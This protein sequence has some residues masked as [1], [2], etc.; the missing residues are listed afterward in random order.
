[1]QFSKLTVD[2]DAKRA[3]M[4]GPIQDDNTLRIFSWVGREEVLWCFSKRVGHAALRYALNGNNYYISLYPAA[5]N[6]NVLR[7]PATFSDPGGDREN[8]FRPE[9][10]NKYHFKAYQIEDIPPAKMVSM[11]D[12]LKRILSVNEHG[13]AAAAPAV[14][15]TD[16][17]P[18]LDDDD[19]ALQRLF[20]MWS[21]SGCEPFCGSPAGC[22][23]YYLCC[24]PPRHNCTSIIVLLLK[25]AGIT[26]DLS[27]A[28]VWLNQ[29]FF[30]SL[31]ITTGYG[32]RE[33]EEFFS[34]DTGNTKLDEILGITSVVLGLGV[35]LPIVYNAFTAAMET[36]IKP[37]NKLIVALKFPR[38]KLLSCLRHSLCL[39]DHTMLKI[40]SWVNFAAALLSLI[41]FTAILGV[42]GFKEEGNLG[43]SGDA[44][45]TFIIPSATYFT[46]MAALAFG[47]IVFS[48]CCHRETGCITPYAL[49][50]VFDRIQDTMP[51][52]DPEPEPN[53]EDGAQ[54]EEAS[55]GGGVPAERR[56]RVLDRIQ[57]TMPQPQ[58]D[59]DSSDSS[60]SPGE[61][62]ETTT[63]AVVWTRNALHAAAI[64][65]AKGQSSTDIEL[66]I[67]T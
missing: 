43:F 22:F 23:T 13:Q 47:Q 25:K 27:C 53:V 17:I 5:G 3:A 52:P 49:S 58:P 48:A 1:M 29:F 61:V 60:D 8:Y 12:A 65:E 66:V 14:D 10:I 37:K 32:F 42:R 7:T 35:G 16:Q 20:K 59:P 62:V 56:L 6:H 57:D 34:G 63:A 2:T 45:E 19:A 15:F 41:I 67:R 51:Q 50:R 9:Q 21:C 39:S 46:A 44:E 26:S 54:Q 28:Q 55:A 64:S 38:E 31:A 24:I 40:S 4:L 33:A 36:I 30:L 18:E 11:H